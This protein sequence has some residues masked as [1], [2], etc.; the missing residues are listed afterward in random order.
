MQAYRAGAYRLK[1]NYGME[2][3]EII[4]L[5]IEYLLCNQAGAVVAS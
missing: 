4:L 3:A 5:D 1:L 2:V